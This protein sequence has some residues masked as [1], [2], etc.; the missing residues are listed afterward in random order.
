[1]SHILNRYPFW[2]NLL[3][4][5]M[6]VFGILYALPNLFPE[7]PALQI[8]GN[9]I[10]QANVSTAKQVMQILA[11]QGIAYQ[12]VTLEG[13]KIVVRLQN[14]D[15]QLQ[16]K[17]EVQAT[18]GEQYTTAVNLV[19]A[20]PAWLQNVGGA[21]MTLGLDLRGGVHFLL[22]VD[23]DSVMTKRAIANMRSI[24]DGLRQAQI[25]YAGIQP[26]K[27]TGLILSFRDS[28][29][30]NAAQNLLRNKFND[31]VVNASARD[32]NYYLQVNLTPAA[33]AAIRDYTMSQTMQV[34]NN[35]VDAL[36]VAEAVIMRQGLD[37]ISV[38]LPGVQDT[39]Q[40][41][42]ILGGNATLEMHLVNEN[43]DLQ[44][45]THGIVPLGSQ[46]YTMVDGSSIVLYNK[47]ILT[48]DAITSASAGVDQ[49]GLPAVN[50]VATGPQ[51]PEFHRI[52]GDNIGKRMGIV[53]VNVKNTPVNINGAMVNKPKTVETVI[54]AAV[55]QSALPGSFMVNGL[56]TSQM[57][58]DLA[59]QLR[60]GT[61]PAALFPIQEL[62]VGPSLGKENI[63][64]GMISVIVGFILIVIFMTIYYRLFGVFANIALLL[65]L[66]LIVAFMSLIGF[67]LTLPGI[68][69]I[70]LTLG[71]AVDANVLIFERI[72][73]ELRNGASPQAAIH[74]GYERAFTTIVDANMTTLIVAIILF[75][76]AS[77]SVK[78]FAITLIIGLL[79]SMITAIMGTRAIVNV[80][81]G[82]R[83]VKKLSIGI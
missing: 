13:N 55:I 78:S 75:A 68:A 27:P 46:L 6:V 74:A 14:T 26:G 54:N 30:Q 35:R 29:A 8:S 20:T 17:D 3:L 11:Q 25:R 33:L 32:G 23:L 43:A 21:P 24:A 28:S 72:R 39:A 40:A 49:N 81:Y 7:V 65:N 73:E 38:D 47:I 52:T 62:L 64:H 66:V 69:G 58:H 77:S 70:V 22:Q 67:T 19:P 12:S 31:Y 1:M 37:R 79:T 16:A 36:G 9:D 63:N 56:Q 82:G 15:S 41:S 80:V 53:L 4:I 61:T 45:A 48:G 10:T 44:A 57:A 60:S 5:G 76:I 50:I 59:I 2:K 18:L 42:Q 83:Q 34:L 71:I 51:I